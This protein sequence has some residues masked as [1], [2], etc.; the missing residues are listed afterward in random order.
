MA[1][2]S[3]TGEADDKIRPRIIVI[4]P[5]ILLSIISRCRQTTLTPK[6]HVIKVLVKR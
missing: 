4:R 2:P 1:V 5:L 3:I 6:G